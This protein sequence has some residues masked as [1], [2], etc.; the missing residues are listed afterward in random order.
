MLIFIFSTKVTNAF[1]GKMYKSFYFWH[2]CV[3]VLVNWSNDLF[4][5]SSIDVIYGAYH[6]VIMCGGVISDLTLLPAPPSVIHSISPHNQQFIENPIMPLEMR[7]YRPAGN[8]L[9]TQNY[10]RLWNIRYLIGYYELQ[11]EVN[12]NDSAIYQEG[13]ICLYM[14]WFS[15]RCKRTRKATK[16]TLQ[17]GRGLR[18]QHVKEAEDRQKCRKIV[19]K[20]KYPPTKAVGVTITVQEDTG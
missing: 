16:N 11:I 14:T 7:C 1:G 3:L 8:Y 17:G 6:Q 20:S 15:C 4:Q 2:H 12:F 10:Q 13:R 19:A 18:V 9:E 5:V